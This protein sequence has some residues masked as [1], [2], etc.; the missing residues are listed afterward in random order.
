M[1]ENQSLTTDE[2]LSVIGEHLKA[3]RL[4]FEGGTT[5][6]DLAQLAG[7]SVST[8][9][10]LESGKGSSL[11][12]FVSVLRALGMASTLE[13]LRPAEVINPMMLH[14]SGTPRLR[15]PSKSRAKRT[16]GQ[17]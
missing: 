8:L 13:A 14:M 1:L 7:V 9:A 17:S 5:R 4:E 15:A 6:E 16:G 12:T 2:W 11:A 3:Q 10:A